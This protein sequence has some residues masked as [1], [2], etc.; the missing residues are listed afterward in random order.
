MKE[1]WTL[2]GKLPELPLP[3]SLRRSI[4]QQLDANEVEAK[5]VAFRAIRAPWWLAQAA[6]VTLLVGGSFYVGRSQTPSI[7]PVGTPATV[8]APTSFSLAENRVLSTSQI[9]PEI[10]GKPDIQNVRFLESENPGEVAVSFD[11]TSRMT[12]TGKPN[13]RSLV[14]ILSYMMQNGDHPTPARSD[15]MQWVKDTYSGQGSADPEIVKALTNV[16]K[17]DA[18][19]GVRIKAVETLKSL[20]ASLLPDARTAL[21]EALKNDPNPS[22]RIKAVEALANLANSGA[23]LDA[24]TLDTLR[25]KAS[26]SDENLYVRVKA[27]EALSQVNF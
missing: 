23:A 19:E 11:L 3:Q 21:M 27:A 9:N 14:R 4:L 18:H 17:S 12:V 13:D 24:A 7:G 22:V 2:L 25:Q 26:Q 20:P 6:A 16:L 1:T 8:A 5:V 15:T 10:E